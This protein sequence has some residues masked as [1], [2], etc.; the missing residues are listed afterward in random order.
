MQTG[1]QFTNSPT[2][3]SRAAAQTSLH[4]MYTF[5]YRT[6]INFIFFCRGQ[7]LFF[8][9]KYSSYLGEISP[10]V[11]NEIQRDFH[12]DKPNK[13][14]LTD[15]TEFKIGEGKVYLSPIID[16]FDGMPITWTVGTSPNAELVNTMLDNAIVLLKEN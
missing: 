3:P 11:P 14:W 2:L 16:C 4:K 12:A 15:I 8:L 10:A 13:K 6:F 7:A 9:K 5:V 1:S